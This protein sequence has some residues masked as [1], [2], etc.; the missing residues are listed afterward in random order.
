[1]KNATYKHLWLVIKVLL[2]QPSLNLLRRGK[3]S[4]TLE[5]MIVVEHF[6]NTQT[7]VAFH[8]TYTT[9]VSCTTLAYCSVANP[10]TSHYTQQVYHTS[11][12][13]RRNIKPHDHTPWPLP[14]HSSFEP[15]HHT[16]SYYCINIYRP[17]EWQ[18]MSPWAP[19]ST[20]WVRLCSL[21]SH[22]STHIQVL[23]QYL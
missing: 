8:S 11:Q 2:A 4:T 23:Q 21:S 6:S 5:R 13:F 16:L 19:V 7:I 14:G 15:P 9:I 1:M 17:D 10:T 18:N 3:K 22:H 12:H 20:T